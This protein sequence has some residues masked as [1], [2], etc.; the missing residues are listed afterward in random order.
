M[1]STHSSSTLMVIL[2]NLILFGSWESLDFLA[3]G[4]YPQVPISHCYMP[5]FKFLILCVSS[6][7]CPITDSAPHFPLPLLCYSPS[8]PLP[9]MSVLFPLLRNIESSIFWSSF[10]LS[11]IWSVNC[12]LGI[13]SFVANIHLSLSAY[14]VLSFMTQLPHTGWY[15]IVPSISLKF[16]LIY[17]FNS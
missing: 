14:H 13:A 1:V 5:L 6:P 16:S 4:D 2:A 3:S 12:I 9:H 11:F 17:C 15:F 7:S 10:F 8:H